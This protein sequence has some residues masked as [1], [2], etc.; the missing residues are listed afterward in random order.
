MQGMRVQSL[1]EE[2]RS[3]M[4]LGQ[5]IKKPQK[6]SNIVT[7][8]IKTL[9][10]VHIKKIL[11]LPGGP[12]VKNLCVNAGDSGSIPTPGRFHM[13]WGNEAP[14]P[15]LLSPPTAITEACVP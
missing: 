11:G 2:L 4:L 1:E 15:Q 12:V 6:R 13:L 10:T 5:E 9:K 14:D 3:H 8:S 7:S